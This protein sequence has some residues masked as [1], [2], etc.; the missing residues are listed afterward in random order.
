[1]VSADY[2]SYPV[3]GRS[4]CWELVVTCGSW[5]T[6]ELT[7]VRWEEECLALASKMV[8]EILEEVE[9]ND[10]LIKDLK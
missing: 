9:V 2:C 7:F 3:R 6:W 8:F 1:M 10:D 4:C 5:W